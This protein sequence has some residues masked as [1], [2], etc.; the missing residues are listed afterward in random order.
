MLKTKIWERYFLGEFIKTLLFFLSTFYT[1]YVLIDYANH[2]AT[3]HRYHI[4]FQWKEFFLYYLC[5]FA[6]RLE[7][8][9]PFALLVTTIRTLCNLNL[10][11]ELIA[12]MSAGNSLKM[13]MRPFVMLGV[14]CAGL[15]YLNN[16]FILPTAMQELKKIEESR[17]RESKKFRQDATVQHLLLE[18][19]STIVF[20][21]YDSSHDLFLDAYWIRSLED[22]YRIKFLSPNLLGIPHGEFVDHFQRGTKGE[23]TKTEMIA[24]AS[25]PGMRFN[26]QTLFE[27]INSPEEEALSVLS[28]MLPENSREMSERDALIQTTFYR[29][30]IVPWLCVLAIIG[31]MP[32]CLR[33][34]RQL[35]LFFIYA[36]SI[37]G[38]V[39]IFLILSTATLLGK[40][41]IAPAAW[42]LFPPMGVFSG[43][44]IWRFFRL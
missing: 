24:A 25:F 9:L 26:R 41:Q 43:F 23:L 31:P 35:P 18:D 32:F 13:L 4:Q 7:V 37:F 17:S 16:E 20:G 14:I 30:L 11:N 34:T 36:G 15:M 1:L 6:I 38:L 33:R 2:T 29:K 44:F 22:V 12:L 19:G 39:A 10:H 8:L 40:R 21:S 5:E 27:T 3:F 42:T 28:K